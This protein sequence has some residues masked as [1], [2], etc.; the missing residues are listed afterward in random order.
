[1]P[2]SMRSRTDGQGSPETRLRRS[3]RAGAALACCGALFVGPGCRGAP[4]PELDETPEPEVVAA[5]LGPSDGVS[6]TQTLRVR[7]NQALDPGTV[8]AD[9]V[10]LVAHTAGAACAGAWSCGEASCVG[11]SCQPRELDAGWISD[12]AHPPLSAKRGAE[13]ALVRTRLEEEGRVLAVDP[14]RPLPS[15]R[16][17][18]LLLGPGITDRRGRRLPRRTPSGLALIRTFVTGGADLARPTV[19][20]VA[21]RRGQAEVPTN[22]ARVA[23][24]FSRPVRGVAEGSLWLEDDHGGRH[25]A[26]VEASDQ[27]CGNVGPSRCWLL[28]PR[29]TLPP[30]G[31][32]RVVASEII[33]DDRGLP[34]LT[35]EVQWFATGAGKDGRSPTVLALLAQ[36]ADDC[37]LVKVWSDE[38]VDVELAVGGRKGRLVSLAK[39]EHEFAVGLP[40]GTEA[41]VLA[42]ASDAAGNL[43]EPQL[44]WVRGES[45]ERVA[46]TEVMPNPAGREPD[47][48]WVELTNLS[49]DPVDLAG[50]TIDDGDD[51]VGAVQL[52]GV[53]LAP[54][55][56]AV[57]VGPGFELPSSPASWIASGAALVRLSGTIGAHGI[58]NRGERLV[59]RDQAG[60]LV[61]TYGGHQVL[62]GAGAEG[63]SVERVPATSCDLRESWRL[64]GSGHGTP[65]RAPTTPGALP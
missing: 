64:S 61:S 63:R 40:Q 15:H 57:L 55:Q 19:E 47:Q 56:V 4:V 30:N 26:A 46:I 65:G 44:R 28:R 54:G 13:R 32:V 7:F 60:R 62:E 2:Q 29:R 59:L 45:P 35:G 10:A 50:W 48:E 18:S 21:P 24:L 52:P 31:S 16:R 12:F 49:S 20:L 22:L 11:G 6:P 36:H 37:V 9:S 39:A 34:V 42:Q 14:L 27:A 51:G 3:F 41:F 23:V 58:G 8:T 33:T 38:P 25:A 17:F 43:A 53:R 1:M 5:E